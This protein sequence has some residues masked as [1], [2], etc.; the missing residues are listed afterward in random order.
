M[1]STR[2]APFVVRMAGIVACIVGSKVGSKV[3]DVGW[4]AYGFRE[5]LGQLN[6]HPIYQSVMVIIRHAC[7]AP[8][9]YN[10]RLLAGAAPGTTNID[11]RH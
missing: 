2:F 4:R 3:A 9:I 1:H 10:S 6:F 8:L 5:A 7:D 11:N